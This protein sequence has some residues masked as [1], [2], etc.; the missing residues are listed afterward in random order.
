MHN[1]PCIHS[2]PGNCSVLPIRFLCLTAYCMISLHF[3]VVAWLTSFLLAAAQDGASV[4]AR[5]L[6]P[7]SG[8]SS[9][10]ETFLASDPDFANET[11]QRWTTHDAPTYIVAVK[12]AVES[13][14][15]KIV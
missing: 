12:P 8:L 7:N 10:T 14:V 4:V 1:F 2:R 5:L 3:L 13:D 6:S 11:T 15:Q 9:G